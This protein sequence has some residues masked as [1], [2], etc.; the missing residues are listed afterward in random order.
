MARLLSIQGQMQQLK[1]D[2]GRLYERKILPKEL[3]KLNS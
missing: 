2:Q 1:Y 3:K